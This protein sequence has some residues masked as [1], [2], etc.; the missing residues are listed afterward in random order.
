MEKLKLKTKLSYGLA[1][2]GDSALYNIMGTFALFFLTTVAGIDPALA[3]TITAIGSVWET[4]CGAVIGYVS[5]NTHT[6]FGKRKPYL[7]VSAL[8]LA[9]LT[10]LFFLNIDAGEG[11]MVIYYGL[12]LVLFWSFF[13]I[14]FVP[15]LA[16]GA[17]LTC[18]YDERTVLRGYVYF[19]N[20]FGTAIGLVLPNILVDLLTKHGYSVEF[21]W[22]TTGILC[23][24]LAG[25]SILIGAL[26]IKD[27]YELQYAGKADEEPRQGKGQG[28]A[29]LMTGLNA[30]LD[31]VR[32]YVEIL[33]LRTVRYILGASV[34]YL[35]GYSIFCS[36]RMYFFTYNMGLSR[37]TITVVM[38]VLTFAS[39]AF[40]PLVS[41]V[42]RWADKRTSYLVGMVICAA[43]M[44]LYG[45]IG[46]TSI[47]HVCIFAIL[48]CIGNIAYWQL[49]PAM[50]YDVCEVDRLINDKE[51]AGL[52]ISL[53]TLAES[54]SNA[55]GLQIMGLILSLS[56]F[57][58]SMEAQTE[59]ALH[60]TNLSFSVI[61]AL[62]MAASAFCIFKYPVTKEMYNKILAGLE[63]RAQG[64]EIDMDE[65]RRLK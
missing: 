61:P 49:V 25:G 9:C 13:S 33:K 59:S 45:F 65:F 7:M 46:V 38:M 57:D 17:E 15:Y 56:G 39:V 11:T 51:R 37:T 42:N 23:G 20:S 53:Q 40:V 43:G 10:G 16:W 36:D 44:A 41:F 58:G 62:F 5:D 14:F 47:V 21:G 29:S 1:G 60:W 28:R 31:M 63:Q 19:F 54:L 27:R 64:R 32:N 18:D 26:G 35:I 34:F 22:Q 8:P 3:G 2:V 48:Y 6:R 30:A 50:I 52:V 4:V 24:A 12:M 55:A